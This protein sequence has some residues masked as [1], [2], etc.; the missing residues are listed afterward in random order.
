[1]KKLSLIVV[2]LAGTQLGATDCGQVLRDPGFDLWC[3]EELCSW[4]VVRG[5]VRRAPTWHASDSGVELAGPDAAISQLAPVTSGD[6]SCIH[7]ELVADVA[8][9][10]EAYLEVDVY[11]DG[12]IDRKER[13][14]ASS[15]RP[16]SYNLRI[17]PPYDGIRFELSKKGAGRAVLG[18]IHAEISAEGCAGLPEI[19][20]GPAPLGGTCLEDA[21]CDSGLCRV[22]P[23]RS[24]PFGVARRCTGCDPMPG[25]PTCGT[26]MVCGYDEPTSPMRGVPIVCLPERADLLGEQCLSHDECASGLC[27]DALICSTCVSDAGCIG[28]ERCGPAWAG[29]P[30]VCSPG[31]RVRQP[32]EPCAGD[33]DCASGACNGGA[34]STCDDGRPCGSP[35][36]TC[37]FDDGLAPGACT[38]VGVTGGS[39]Q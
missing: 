38:R 30:S 16:L 5:E 23:D 25:A 37:P 4:K 15:W 22:V 13:L 3:G 33:L 7:F 32:G 34:R 11:G 8:D 10:A 35:G 19:D 18:R 2:A 36:T 28:D 39:C 24:V 31:G 20:G 29:G 12:S 6:G 27:N 14:P 26:A 9:D 17:K 21:G 1:M